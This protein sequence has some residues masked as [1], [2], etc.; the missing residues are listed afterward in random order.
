MYDGICQYISEAKLKDMLV[1]MAVDGG[2]VNF[3]KYNGALNMMAEFIGQEVFRI[4]C[5]NHRLDAFAN[6][7]EMLD[8]LFRLFRNS[9]KS[10]RIYQLLGEKMS[11]PVLQFLRCGGTRF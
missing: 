11:V 3:G 7:Q 4:H 1:C 2:S 5:A 6:I 8:V 9:R 10:W